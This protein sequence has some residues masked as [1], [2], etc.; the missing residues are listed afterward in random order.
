MAKNKKK[1]D[2][3]ICKNRKAWHDYEIIKTYEAGI[4]LNGN[5][6]KSIRQG[7]VNLKDAYAKINHRLEM[8]VINMY[9]ANY[10]H[11]HLVCN[12]DERC[13]RKLLLHKKELKELAQNIKEHRY[14]LI[15]LSLYYKNN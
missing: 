7:S 9:I 14:T 2:N 10:A 6:I 12:L 1:S 13:S 15:P 4:V 5:E 8:Y 3:T 11:A